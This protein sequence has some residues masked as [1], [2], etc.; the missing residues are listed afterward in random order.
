MINQYAWNSEK[1]DVKLKI[2]ADN[3]VLVKHLNTLYNVI[4]LCKIDSD[5][6]VSWGSP[7]IFHSQTPA[8]NPEAP[9]GYCQ[10]HDGAGPGNGI[11]NHPPQVDF[12]VDFA[13][14]VS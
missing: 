7:I 1:R 12:D 10:I 14:R 11:A 13:P 3:F 4:L 9:A 6:E 8:A 5:Q 2:E